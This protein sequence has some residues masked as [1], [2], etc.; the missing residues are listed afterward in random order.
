MGAEQGLSLMGPCPG[1]LVQVASLQLPA[2]AQCLCS[3]SDKKAR[4]KLSVNVAS[5]PPRRGTE[6]VNESFVVS[7]LPDNSL[8]VLIG[9][10]KRA[11]AA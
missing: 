6:L 2:R 3:G 7:W 1:C 4:G 8:D 11:Q 10:E 5:R 9:G